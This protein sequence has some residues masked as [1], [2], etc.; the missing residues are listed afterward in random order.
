MSVSQCRFSSASGTPRA[1]ARCWRRATGGLRRQGAG[2]GRRRHYRRGRQR[3]ANWRNLECLLDSGGLRMPDHGALCSIANALALA[4]RMARWERFAVSTGAPGP[5][6]RS[7]A[8]RSPRR[9]ALCAALWRELELFSFEL[10]DA[11]S[12]RLHK[13][14]TIVRVVTFSIPSCINCCRTAPLATLLQIQRPRTRA[15]KLTLTPPLTPPQ[16][17]DALDRPGGTPP[18]PPSSAPTRRTW[19]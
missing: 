17:L 2:R 6:A 4:T 3:R 12:L 13:T 18:A 16:P 10:R 7:A 19:R 15:M 11:L 1:F 8:S 9:R 5:P 14:H